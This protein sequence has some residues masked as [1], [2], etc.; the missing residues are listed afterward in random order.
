M[1]YK[2]G[3]RAGV[4]VGNGKTL[5]LHQQKRVPTGK[6]PLPVFFQEL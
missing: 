5:V 6:P 4:K 1:N 2:L 3:A